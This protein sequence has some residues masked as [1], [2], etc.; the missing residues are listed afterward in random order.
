MQK[1]RKVTDLPHL[2][3]L[4]L[5]DLP[6]LPDL[7]DL[8][9][10]E[11]RE[12][13]YESVLFP[14][15]SRNRNSGSVYGGVPF[16]VDTE[17]GKKRSVHSSNQNS[18]SVHQEL[19]LMEQLEENKRD[20]QS[21]SDQEVAKL[22][23]ELKQ[24]TREIDFLAHHLTQNREN[25]RQILQKQEEAKKIKT[26]LDFILSGKCRQLFA[27][28]LNE[29]T[30]HHRIEPVL[31]GRTPIIPLSTS[32]PHS[33]IS[34]H[35]IV[36]S[37]DP[38]KNPVQDLKEKDLDLDRDPDRDRDLENQL[39]KKLGFHSQSKMTSRKKPDLFLD[40]SDP[41]FSHLNTD[42][43]YIQPPLFTSPPV[44]KKKNKVVPDS[45]KSSGLFEIDSV[46]PEYDIANV[47]YLPKS[48]SACIQ[49]A[50]SQSLPDHAFSSGQQSVMNLSN[51]HG[52][53]STSTITAT[54]ANGSA[55]GR[56]SRL[57]CA[58]GQP[59]LDKYDTGKIFCLQCGLSR[60]FQ[61]MLPTYSEE[62]QLRSTPVHT[63]KNS[64]I[65]AVLNP[66]RRIPFV[67]LPELPFT[68]LRK[69]RQPQI[70]RTRKPV[71]DEQVKNALQKHGLAKPFYPYRN[72][73]TTHFTGLPPTQYLTAEKDAYWTS[74]L[75]KKPQYIAEYRAY[76]KRPM[77]E[78]FQSGGAS[79]NLIDYLDKMHP[80]T[81]LEEGGGGGSEERELE[82][83][84]S[85]MLETDDTEES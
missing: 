7:P 80:P 38:Q 59:M 84:E 25:V 72:Q 27:Q 37:R 20:F 60:E 49:A 56:V 51:N 58:C 81:R 66:F 31:S 52:L 32:I 13:N 61:D 30:A 2:D 23:R 40:E 74:T 67:P 39:M 22:Q 75:Q 47:L 5:S 45:T 64:Q 53:S 35:G 9:D 46:P 1:K 6:N 41:L 15:R 76:C 73:I 28:R 14:I 8:P 70:I 85:E 33:S 79:L 48:H 54:S 77:L 65:S 26:K 3:L 36:P 18:L 50:A 42:M 69:E 24:F 43:N 55:L 62:N 21:R 63:K 4:D 71:N 82:T 17:G 10:L 11:H 34:R 12:T 19:S 57:F 16:A 29:L 83:R 68:V 78:K 44:G